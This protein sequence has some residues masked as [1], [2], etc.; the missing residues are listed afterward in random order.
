ML[1][2][3]E[4]FELKHVEFLR[5]I[6]SFYSMHSIWDTIAKDSAEPG[7]A[8]FTRHQSNIYLDLHDDAKAWFTRKGEA[9]FVNMQESTIVQ[10]VR[11]FREQ[12]LGWLEALAN[13]TGV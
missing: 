13:G 4:E 6:K 10:T 8:A 3:L 11:R 2:W 9:R 5:C 12:E 7:H 1:Q